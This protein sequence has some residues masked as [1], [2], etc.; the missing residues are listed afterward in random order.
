MTPRDISVA[1]PTYQREKVL[2]DT[3]ETLLGSTGELELL[4]ID[5]TPAHEAWTTARLG[6]LSAAGRVR[7]LKLDAPSI[8]HAMNVAL[9]EATR[10]VVL[11]LDDDVEP[12]A[13]L[14]AA[15]A[16]SYDD[17]A[18]W[19]VVGQVLQ[20]GELPTTANGR[21]R[22]DGLRAFLDFPFNSTEKAWVT[23]VMAGNLSVRRERA[24]AAGGFDEN[25][26][27]AAYRFETEFCRRLCRSGGRVLF[28]PN[29]RLRHL[30]VASGGTRAHGDHLTSPSSA[31]GVGDY[32]FALRE[33]FGWESV[34]YMVWRP[35][36]K[37]RARFYVRRPWWIPVGLLGEVRAFVLAVRLFQRGPRYVVPPRVLR[38]R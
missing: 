2:I 14:V 9:L 11:F 5:Q 33:G 8:P 15:H 12:A 16:A 38:R 3:I 20:P 7:W 23:N 27:G 28:Q 1:I 34:A 29:A 30:R 35:L 32:Y 36:R 17:P 19:A 4:I 18:L 10:P 21:Y 25:F 26:V 31:H 24:L 22:R 13:G 37:I 6:E